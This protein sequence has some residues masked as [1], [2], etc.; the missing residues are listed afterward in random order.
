MIRKACHIHRNE[1][2]I[3]LRVERQR[4]DD[5]YTQALGHVSLDYVGIDRAH[6]QPGL[7]PVI[8]NRPGDDLAP[9]LLRVV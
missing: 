7:E 3:G 5:S 9:A 6:H 2:A 1:V 4:G 8:E